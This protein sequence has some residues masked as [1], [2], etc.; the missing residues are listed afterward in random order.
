[1][2]YLVK[3]Y[4][5]YNPQKCGSNIDEELMGGSFEWVI[6]AYSKEQAEAEARKDLFENETI[7]SIEEISVK[8][9]I[10]R[11]MEDIIREIYRQYL[12][13]KYNYEKMPVREYAKLQ[14]Q[15]DNSPD[16]HYEAVKLAAKKMLIFRRLKR[17][18]DIDK[19][20]WKAVYNAVNRMAE[21][22]TEEEFD[23]VILEIKEENK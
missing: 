6:K 1:M 8:E 9:C 16:E 18:V 7:T 20:T 5:D 12:V 4:E 2:Y 3:G 10:E 14:R 19:M 17:V 23:K 21:A 22:E 15:F 11:E 13:V